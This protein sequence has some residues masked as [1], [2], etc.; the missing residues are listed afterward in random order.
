MIY[1]LRDL[2]VNGIISIFDVFWTKERLQ[3]I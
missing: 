1:L 2:T 3:L